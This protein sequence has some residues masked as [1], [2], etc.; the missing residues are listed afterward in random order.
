MRY[1]KPNMTAL[2]GEWGRKIF[3]EIV[4][5][6]R[7]DGTSGEANMSRKL[8]VGIQSFE[9]LRRDGYVYVDK[10]AYV[11][12]LVRLSVPYFLSRPRRFG[13][14]LLVSTLRAYFEGRRELFE[15]LEIERLEGDCP[16][17]WQARPVF[18][19]SFNGADY[20]VE[21][22]LESKLDTLLRGLE[23]GWDGAWSDLP[24]GPRFQRLLEVAHERSGHRVAVLV[25]EYDKPLLESMHLPALEERNRAI[26]KGFY[27]VLKGA[28]EHL[29]F[30]FIT[31]VTK[32]SKASIFSDLNQL[33]DISLERDYAGICGVTE[34]EL[35][36]AL[37]PEVDALAVQLGVGRD[38]CVGLLRNQYDGYCFHPDGPEGDSGK[39]YNP[40]SLLNALQKRALGSYWFE[41][42]TPTFLVRRMRE[43]GL[44][45]RRLADG[46]I[47]AT[48]RRLSDYR[49]DDPD[50]VPLLFQTGYLT[51]ES[52][53]PSFGEYSL[54]V[55]NGEVEWGLVESLL[56]AWAPGY[57]ESRGTDVFT[58][59][60]LVEAGNT[61]GVRRVIEALFASIPY[62]RESDPFEN[63][64]QAVLWL[65]FALLGRYVRT[66]VRQA[67][68]RVDCV[69][70]A[71]AHVYVF[72]FKRDG[73]AAEAL[74]QI[75]EK[76][77]AAPFVADRRE[78]HLVG[79]AFDS[80]T[81]LVSDWAER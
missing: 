74:A 26:L 6:P 19:L 12:E 2:E 16:G 3:D 71:R 9:K 70:E 54:A 20:T 28:D 21:G 42:G 59:R 10:T 75:E 17:S 30:V 24:P 56:P 1:G 66:E 8:P 27:S 13:K 7:L 79:C 23:E 44:D 73:T 36:G 51:I 18:H 50:P 34:G 43:V 63:Y 22:G 25:D 37:G 45:P 62:T 61:E 40:Y 72:E 33:R 15:G 53:D 76:G 46:T 41:T 14:S 64:F 32:F 49:A 5:S 31:G 67:L 78:L 11:Y 55:P 80:K 47:Y 58:L 65:V 4:T 57:S 52:Y 81:R 35:L 39:V 68:G 38:A 69:V 77:Y 29:R 48:E 60:R